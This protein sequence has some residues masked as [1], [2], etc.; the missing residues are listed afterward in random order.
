MAEEFRKSAP[1]LR[2]LRNQLIRKVPDAEATKA[3]AA[4]FARLLHDCKRRRWSPDMSPEEV[5]AAA[6]QDERDFETGAPR[7]AQA[8]LV[9]CGYA[10]SQARSLVDYRRKRRE[11]ESETVAVPHG[12]VVR[13]RP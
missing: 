10:P 12:A 11:R 3:L 13:T 8:A 4:K 6:S 2:L 5:A 1:Y 9:A 7:F